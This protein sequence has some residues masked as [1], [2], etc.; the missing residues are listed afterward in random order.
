ML[1]RT[2]VS[3]RDNCSFALGPQRTL[4]L[5]VSEV[6]LS[7]QQAHPCYLFSS[8][9]SSNSITACFHPSMQPLL[10]AAMIK[11]AS[12]AYTQPNTARHGSTQPLP[13]LACTEA[14][15]TPQTYKHT[16]VLGRTPVSVRDNCSFALGPQRTLRL[17]VSE[18]MLSSQQAHPCYLFSS[19]PS[20]N[21]IRHGLLSSLHATTAHSSYEQACITSLRTAEY[22]AAWQH[23][24]VARSCLH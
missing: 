23:A 15:A 11:H 12:Q 22:G 14:S 7:S 10:I 8:P 5:E 20:S 17:E 2:P 4:R 24:T 1:G 6:M 18:V 19:P 9:P 3:V 13:G 21:S 16:N